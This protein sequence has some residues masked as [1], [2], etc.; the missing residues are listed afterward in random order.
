MQICLCS[1]PV[2]QH[3]DE[4]IFQG[5][6]IISNWMIL[7]RRGNFSHKNQK[8]H[9]QLNVFCSV[10]VMFVKSIIR[11][12]SITTI[13]A[14]NESRDDWK[15]CLNLQDWWLVSEKNSFL[16]FTLL[17]L[18]C[19]K[20]SFVIFLTLFLVQVCSLPAQQKPQPSLLYGFPHRSEVNIL[21]Q[22]KRGF[23]CF[24]LPAWNMLQNPWGWTRRSQIQVIKERKNK[25]CIF[26]H[27]VNSNC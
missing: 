21:K 7:Q 25:K 22:T 10:Y 3:A 14:L 12:T 15:L 4:P 23:L 27:K 18:Q 8:N 13:A 17:V 11:I 1:I 6:T 19:R 9:K 16:G 5:G 2:D 24:F 26:W 20:V